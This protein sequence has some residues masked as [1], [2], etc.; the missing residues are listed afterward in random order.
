VPALTKYV[1]FIA[2]LAITRRWSRPSQIV[3]HRET[4]VAYRVSRS[5]T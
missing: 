4:L 2:V 1:I 5:G 3:G